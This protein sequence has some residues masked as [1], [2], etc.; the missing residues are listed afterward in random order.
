M[1][2]PISM[3]FDTESCAQSS[4]TAIASPFSTGSRAL[5]SRRFLSEM[6]T[7]VEVAEGVVVVV[8]L[9]LLRHGENAGVGKPQQMLKVM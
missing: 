9:L 3:K 6:T 4:V 5:R 7:F 1:P 2:V 8:L